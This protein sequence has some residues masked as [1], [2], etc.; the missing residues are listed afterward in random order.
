MRILILYEVKIFHFWRCN[1]FT[2]RCE[3]FSLLGPK[4]SWF[5][6]ELVDVGLALSTAF[7]GKPAH[8]LELFEVGDQAAAGNAHVLGDELLARVAIVRLPS[9]GKEQGVRELG[10]RRDRVGVEKK[11]RH[12]REATS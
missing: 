7:D 8:L 4:A 9:G 12:H 1:R 3:K 10:A 5:E 6:I 11:I 2:Y